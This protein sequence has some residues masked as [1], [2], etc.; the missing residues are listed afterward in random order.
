MTDGG[1]GGELRF[2]VRRLEPHEWQ[3]FR[4]LRLEAL[5]DAPSAFITTMEQALAAPEAQWR[6][7]IAASPHF[8]A[9][10]GGQPAGIAVGFLHDGAPELVG[11]WVKPWARGAGAVQVLLEAVGGWAAEEGHAELVLWV[12]VGNERAERAYRRHGFVH[13]GR[14]QL[15]PGRPADTEVEMAMALRAPGA[16]LP[17]PGE[18]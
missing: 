5:A 18:P 17:S 12:V 14:S 3:R 1:T 10:A 13:T 8:L 6:E 7:R 9:E 11:M 2:T 4:D 16:A 15:V